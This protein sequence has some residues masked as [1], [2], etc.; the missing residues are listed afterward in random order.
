MIMPQLTGFHAPWAL[1]QL[2]SLRVRWSISYQGTPYA[3]GIVL[4]QSPAAGSQITGI[5]ALTVSAGANFP[6]W[7]QAVR[8]HSAGGGPD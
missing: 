8:S 1:Q 5:I 7:H 6:A 2:G 4:A 3:T